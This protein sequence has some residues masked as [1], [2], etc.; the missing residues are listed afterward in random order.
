MSHVAFLRCIGCQKEWNP[1]RT[2]YTCPECD[3]LL[4]VLYD[5]PKVSLDD[6][7]TS[8]DRSI[9]RYRALLPLDTWG[10][11]LTVG[12][13][14][15][16]PAPRLAERLG[17]KHVWVKDDGRN[18]TGSL[19]DRA[20]SVCVARARE[21]GEKL[22][23]AASTGNAASSLSGLAASVGLQTVIFVPK[24][25]PQAKVAQLLIYGARVMMV[26]GNY[27]QAFDLCLHATRKFGW[28]S[29]NTGFNPY[30]LEG[31]KTV[32]LEIA[33]DLEWQAPDRVFV[34][35]GDGCILAGVWKGF[36]DLMQVGRLDRMPRLMA[37]QAEGA[38]ALLTL[39][40]TGKLPDRPPQTV[41]DSIS[42][43]IPRAGAQAVR[44]LRESK[45]EGVRVS[46][47]EIL[48]AMRLLARDTGVF[49]EPAGSA[50]VAGLMRAVREG[51]VS[52]D[53]RVVVIVTGNGLKDVA[54]AMQAVDNQPVVVPP[55][56]KALEALVSVKEETTV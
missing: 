31:K 33:E 52:A 45:G 14:P 21:L 42:V 4:D 29:R 55:D 9:W 53:E 15:L 41:A 28:Y 46:D 27:D 56:P 30:L 8:R 54:G 6:L 51:R 26:E 35:A 18:P 49:A 47:R 50:A 36:Y 13:T 16:Y 19:K 43:G 37:V 40:E 23:T 12:G 44:A 2:R 10:L 38:D 17:L 48:E 22:I 32:A 7:A 5:Y 11:P 1:D 25:A 39:L 3:S 20:S 34:S 24:T